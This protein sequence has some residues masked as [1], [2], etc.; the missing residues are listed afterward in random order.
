MKNSFPIFLLLI[1]LASCSPSEQKTQASEPE[2]PVNTIQIRNETAQTENVLQVCLACHRLEPAHGQHDGLTAP[3]FPG[4]VRHY[5][6]RYPD[7]ASFM[8]AVKDYVKKPSKEKS[9]MPGAV[10]RFG[11]MPPLPLDDATLD[12]IAETLY[13]LKLP[14]RG[15]MKKKHRN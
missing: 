13:L 8:K 12:K 6:E 15:K 7:K 10:E 3:P 4:V 9:L 5:K 2:S 11:L 1:F 14:Q